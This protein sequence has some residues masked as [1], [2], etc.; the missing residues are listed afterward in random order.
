MSAELPVQ[1]ALPGS[2]QLSA[3]GRFWWDGRAWQPTQLP[4]RPPTAQPIEISAGTAFKAGFFALIGAC[5]ASAAFW[6]LL[7]IGLV[8]FGS[9]IRAL[10]EQHAGLFKQHRARPEPSAACTRSEHN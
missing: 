7:I 8:L 4:P 1:P 5:A 6:I 3:H 2:R 10:T 9:A